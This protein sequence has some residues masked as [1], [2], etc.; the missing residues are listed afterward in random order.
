MRRRIRQGQIFDDILAVLQCAPRVGDAG[1]GVLKSCSVLSC[2]M[3]TYRV[4]GGASVSKS[5]LDFRREE[6]AS[7]GQLAVSYKCHHV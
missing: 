7:V 6:G 2:S 1:L 4:Y 5:E 3:L